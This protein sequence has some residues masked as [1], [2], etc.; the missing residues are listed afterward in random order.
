MLIVK[1]TRFRDK[2]TCSLPAVYQNGVSHV[3]FGVLQN[4]LQFPKS[5][6]DFPAWFE[7]IEG[8]PIGGKVLWN[9]LQPSALCA[10]V[11][12]ACGAPATNRMLKKPCSGK[13]TLDFVGV[14]ACFF[15]Q[16]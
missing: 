2:S 15:C 5:T 4:A 8:E 1:E 13:M 12:W 11:L 9:K 7:K 3:C 14:F 10:Y 6:K 16:K